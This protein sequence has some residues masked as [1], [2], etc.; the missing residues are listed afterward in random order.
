M[1]KELAINSEHPQNQAVRIKVSLEGGKTIFYYW[2][3]GGWGGWGWRVCGGCDLPAGNASVILDQ[4]TVGWK[5]RQWFWN[6]TPPYCTATSTSVPTIFISNHYNRNW[7][8]VGKVFSVLEFFFF[9]HLCFRVHCCGIL[10]GSLGNEVAGVRQTKLKISLTVY[11]HT[12]A[13]QTFITLLHTHSSVTLI[14][15]CLSAL[16]SPLFTLSHH[17]LQYSTLISDKPSHV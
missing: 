11:Y 17:S 3:C 1:L 2:N 8:Q 13:L 7:A 15:L 4:N 16:V 9:I 6:V 12:F 5:M 10:T 14:S